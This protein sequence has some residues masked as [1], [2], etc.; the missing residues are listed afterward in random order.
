M[1]SILD[2]EAKRMPNIEE[3]RLLQQATSHLPLRTMSQRRSGES[4]TGL[5]TKSNAGKGDLPFTRNSTQPGGKG[6]GCCRRQLPVLFMRQTSK[7]IGSLYFHRE[8]GAVWDS[9]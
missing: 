9:G 3:T 1:S 6:I 5:A 2:R 4:E 7:G 8:L